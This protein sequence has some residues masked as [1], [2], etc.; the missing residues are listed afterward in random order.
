MGA[1]I[2]GGA[3]GACFIVYAC[4]DVVWLMWFEAA[5]LNNYERCAIQV[6]A[7]YGN[8]GSASL[9]TCQALFG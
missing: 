9:S 7:G 2:V 3:I 5:R 8:V 6:A 4:V 1:E